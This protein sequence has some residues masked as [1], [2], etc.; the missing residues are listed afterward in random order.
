[1]NQ[2]QLEELL[3]KA[4]EAGYGRG[5]MDSSGGFQ[6]EQHERDEDLDEILTEALYDGIVEE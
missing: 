1:M 5:S 2:A 3:I 6:K 4:F